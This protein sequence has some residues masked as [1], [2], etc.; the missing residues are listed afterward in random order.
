MK[1]G[2]ISDLH[3]LEVHDVRPWHFL[4][5]RLVGG[6]NLLLNRGKRH[7]PKVVHKA[8]SRLDELGVDHIAI[9][10]DLTNLALPSEFQAARRILDTIPVPH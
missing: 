2:H 8:L 4:N 6:T 10:G 7:S 5:K 3:I 1:I 9:T